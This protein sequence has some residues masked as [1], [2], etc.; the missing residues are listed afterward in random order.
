LR[1]KNAVYRIMLASKIHGAVVTEANLYYE[2]S[3]SL[4][5]ELLKAADLVPY[6]QV[7]VYNLDTGARFETYLLP[8]PA[9]SG[10]VCLN[11]AA[12]RLGQVGDRLIIAAYRL[13][14]ESQVG[15]FLTTIVHVDQ[16]N[17]IR[18][19]DSL[20]TKPSKPRSRP[21]QS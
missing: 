3:L 14:E 19:S 2:G 5:R 16:E 18:A 21:R 6:Q 10:T 12:A 15:I 13:V 8:A 17:R 20:P 1:G 9:G 4:D 7:Q 11:G